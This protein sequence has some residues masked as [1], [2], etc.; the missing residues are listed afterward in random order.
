MSLVSS[1]SWSRVLSREWRCSWSSADRRCSNYIWVIDNFMTYQGAS[2]IRGLRVR[3]AYLILYVFK[4]DSYGRW[5]FP[6]HITYI[7][8]IPGI[9]Q[10]IR[11]LWCFVVIFGHYND[12]IMGATASQIT[13]LTIV[14][15]TVYSG[16][17]QRKHQSSASLAFVRGIHQWPVNSPHKGP[18]TRKMFSFVDVIMCW[19]ILPIPPSVTS[20]TMEQS[21]NCLYATEAI[22]RNMGKLISL[23]RYEPM[24]SPQQTNYDKT[25]CISNGKSVHDDLWISSPNGMALSLVHDEINQII[26]H[27]IK[28]LWSVICRELGSPRLLVQN[29]TRDES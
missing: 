16:T 22:L 1:H 6:K 14:Y 20:H 24:M 18:V 7:Q 5:L 11:A 13:S 29:R 26:R 28:P 15:S 10:N 19:W 8:Y 2:Y 21:R 17:D 12:I 23:I 9:I 27:K 4:G 25:V 3:I